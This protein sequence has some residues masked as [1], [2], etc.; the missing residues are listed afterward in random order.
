MRDRL[1]HAIGSELR[2][3]EGLVDRVDRSA[4]NRRGRELLEPGR[5]QVA[6]EPSGEQIYEFITMRDTKRVVR[7][8]RIVHELGYIERAAECSELTLTVRRDQDG[9]VLRRK[10]PVRCD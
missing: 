6:R 3:R 5:G 7:K 2:L 9:A 1:D 10:C 4:G 8:A